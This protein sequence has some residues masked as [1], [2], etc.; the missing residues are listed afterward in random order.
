[1]A[2]PFDAAAARLESARAGFAA[3][4]PAVDDRAPWPLATHFGVEPEAS[5]GPP[6]VLAHVTE[7]LPFWLGEIERI[8]AGDP[9]PVPFGRVSTDPL[10]LGVIG[11]DRTLPLRELWARLD[12]GVE[13]YLRRLPELDDAAA[14]RRGLHQTAGE[15]TVEAILERFVVAHLEDH[16]RQLRTI[17]E[18]SSR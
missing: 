17:L 12:A 8:L 15:L 13:R 6:E 4:R 10:R 5:W 9:E 18:D 2:R 3:L 1:M 7:M 11:R 14:A 16:V